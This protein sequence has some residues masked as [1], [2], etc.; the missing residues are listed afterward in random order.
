MPS[1]SKYALLWLAAVLVAVIAGI[2]QVR[3]GFP[4]ETDILALLPENRKDRAANE[5]FSLFA[6]GMS[7]RVVFVI[8]VQKRDEV[9]PAAAALAGRLRQLHLFSIVNAEVRQD[10]QKAWGALY[11]PRRHQLLHEAQRERLSRQ[12][13]EQVQTVLYAVYNP[14]SGITS[15]EF[16]NDPFLLFREYLSGI[17]KG[18]PSIGLVDGYL[19][20][21]REGLFYT[22]ITAKLNGSPYGMA[23]QD[24]L[25]DLFA[26]EAEVAGQ[27]NAE[28]FHTGVVFY[29]AHGAGRA[30]TEI[31]TIGLGSLA[32]ILLLIILVYRSVRPLF[33]A[34]LSVSCGVLLAFVITVAVFGKI[35]LFSLVLGASLIG[36]SIDYAFHF[37]TARLAA[38]QAWNAREGLK[39]ILG[40]MTMGLVTTLIGY[41]GLLVAPFPG[42]QQLSLFSS[43]GLVAAFATV[44]FWY[45]VLAR[46]PSSHSE[47]RALPFSGAIEKWIRF[48]RRKFIR[49]TLPALV[50]ILAAAGLAG[51]RYDD[52]IR[53]LQSLPGE[54]KEQEEQIRLITGLDNSQ[55]LLLIRGGREEEVLQRDEQVSGRLDELINEGALAG[56]TS[57]S[58][59]VPPEKTQRHN[60]ELVE[61]LYRDHGPELEQQ[62]GLKEPVTVKEAFS[63]LRVRDFLG[64][65]ASEPVRFLWADGSDNHPF[66][67]ILLQ[68]V[69]HAD[70]IKALA[71]R[72]D[73]VTYLDK[74]EEVSGLFGSY[75]I[76]IMELILAAYALIVL[77][78]SARYGFLNGLR[79]ITPPAVA[80]VAGLSVTAL[81]GTPL[82]MFNF[83]A[84]VLVLG[85]GIDYALFFAE[86]HQPRNIMLSVTLAAMTTLLS[87]G[88]LSLSDTQAIHSFGVTVLA[89]V[90]VAWLLSP[91]AMKAGREAS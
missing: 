18:V 61:R 36:V 79:I 39:G 15:A 69:M 62:L 37:L 38:G 51:V 76:R 9:K 49:R 87:F 81:T 22:L 26:A 19:C 71:D 14:F 72:I 88:L 11:F 57:I 83:L 85:I 59:F 41:L 53:Q 55:Q 75:R 17:N 4:V 6:D 77:M 40:A 12:P 16:E 10:E 13:Q 3:S 29:A 44:V 34:L 31:S 2:F 91:F 82:N 24:Q 78:L 7:D 35:H 8:R 74:A 70:A 47:T 1:T 73:G 43:S 42:L 23:L 21:E 32:G 84:M 66:A 80:S 25:P 50:V 52:D 63:P 58:S 86:H 5:A 45:P 20:V 68:G 60:R 33:L 64:S 65:E 30:R 67:L 46:S 54:L 27:F 28:I 89:G 90:L 56:Y 48:W